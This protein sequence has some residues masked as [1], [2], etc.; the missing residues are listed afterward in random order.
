[1]AIETAGVK[2][3]SNRD[4][5]AQCPLMPAGAIILAAGS[6]TRM[7]ALKQLLPYGG[8]TLLTHSIDQ[9]RQ[10]GFERIIVVIGAES[11]RV[12]SAI[13]GASVEIVVNENWAAGM[14]SSITAGLEWFRTEG[15]LLPVLGIVLVDQPWISSEHL[16]AMREQL[17]SSDV[18]AIAAEY[19]NGLGAP[20]LFREQMYPLLAALPPGAGAKHLLR[21]SGLAVSGFPLPEAATDID[22]PSDFASLRWVRT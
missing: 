6:A 8:G 11:E 21:D 18:A 16:R 14:G 17:Q 9:V 4:I 1:M 7:G 22:T 15:S 5:E 10:A 19:A 13:A 20:A 12:R 2:I 3:N